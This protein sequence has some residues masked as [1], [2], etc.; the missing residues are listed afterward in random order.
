VWV[1]GAALTSVLTGA[2]FCA[3]NSLLRDNM[4]D[5]QLSSGNHTSALF[6]Y[7]AEEISKLLM[8]YHARC[9]NSTFIVAE[10]GWGNAS[11]AFSSS[12]ALSTSSTPRVGI[13]LPTLRHCGSSGGRRL[14]SE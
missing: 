14:S 13:S 5:S 9:P 3:C 7:G 12:S 2:V 1:V 4:L 10:N 8:W 6:S 11:Y